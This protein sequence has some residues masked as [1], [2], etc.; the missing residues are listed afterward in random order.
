MNAYLLAYHW[1]ELVR[2]F[3]DTEKQEGI[4]GYTT[5]NLCRT[6]L[7][8]IR[9]GRFRQYN[10][11]TQKRDEEFEKFYKRLADE[12]TEELVK[13]FLEDDELWKTTLEMAEQ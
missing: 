9:N 11:F 6:A 2:D 7:D 12:F 1:T 8:Y 5:E 3:K 4:S 13:R 10:L